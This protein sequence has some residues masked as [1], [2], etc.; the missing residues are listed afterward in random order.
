MACHRAASVYA[1]ARQESLRDPTV[2][3]RRPTPASSAL[4][5]VLVLA[6]CA[7][8][9]AITYDP[10]AASVGT[11]ETVIVATDRAPGTGNP[12]F[13]QRRQDPPH[14][15]RFEISVPPE[16]E[17]GTIT[18]PRGHAPDPE[19][20]FLTV[21]AW[22]LGGEPG[23]ITAVNRQLALDPSASGDVML[24]THG[25]NTNFAEGLYRQAQLQH[26]MG[27]RSVQVQFAW[28]SDG[29]FEGYLYDRESVLFSRDALELTIAA[30]ARTR[31]RKL[32]LVAHSMGTLLMMDTLR[33]MARVGY[34]SV[35]AKLGGVVL[36]SPDIEIDVFRRQA[37]PL[38]ERGVPITVVVSTRDR[39]LRASALIR[40]ERDRV[41]SVHSTEELGVPGV[42]V[43]DIS[44][45]TD[46]GFTDHFAVATSPELLAFLRS[47]HGQ[48]LSALDQEVGPLE[49]G[50]ALVQ[51]GASLVL[52]PL[53]P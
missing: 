36:L 30:L 7:P 41:G 34:D 14:F 24:F 21:G 19:T 4:A 18:Y 17:I 38:I 31:A 15:L 10:A 52:A 20:D 28:P 5:A 11:V 51:H 44:D 16:R 12:L 50:A 25:Y 23:F 9:G 27:V 3:A 45:V 40:G 47:L 42:T 46:P 48:G 29:K 33:L 6:A 39:A 8:R 43:I 13:T 53:V 1:D 32:N 26:D 49:A 22:N 37:I 35:F 2:F